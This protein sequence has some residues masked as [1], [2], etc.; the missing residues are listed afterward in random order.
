MHCLLIDNLTAEN[1]NI[2]TKI[3]F[4]LVA[5]ICVNP[6]RKF[7]S[8]VNQSLRIRSSEIENLI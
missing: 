6:L 2:T 3:E 1:K 7:C 8:N 5:E 4:I